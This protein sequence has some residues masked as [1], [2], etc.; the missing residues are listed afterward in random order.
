MIIGYMPSNSATV[1]MILLY[2]IISC[3]ALVL[4]YLVHKRGA[5]GRCCGCGSCCGNFWHLTAVLPAVAILELFGYAERQEM[6][7]SFGAWPYLFSSASILIAPV[8]LG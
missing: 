6:I 3:V 8:I 2:A 7:V 4:G 1:A 5:R